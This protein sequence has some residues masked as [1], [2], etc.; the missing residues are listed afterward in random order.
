MC[1]LKKFTQI[2]SDQDLFKF[3]LLLTKEGLNILNKIESTVLDT[4]IIRNTYFLLFYN[5]WNT[6]TYKLKKYDTLIDYI[7]CNID[8][9][10]LEAKSL[11]LPEIHDFFK[12]LPTNEKDSIIKK[13]ESNYI[14]ELIINNILLNK[15]KKEL[16]LKDCFYEILLNSFSKRKTEFRDSTGLIQSKSNDSRTC[17]HAY[18]ITLDKIYFKK[19]DFKYQEISSEEFSLN[20]IK[21]ISFVGPRHY[22]DFS[23]NMVITFSH[24]RDIGIFQNQDYDSRKLKEVL[25]LLLE[26]KN[27]LIKRLSTKSNIRNII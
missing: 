13:R 21:F 19:L 10:S 15:F 5:L 3:H 17:Y 23:R 1:K 22:S 24:F 12:I 20:D 2:I 16:N 27:I 14:N 9:Y 11:S 8:K 25:L 18:I 26:S 7:N 6:E 4:Q